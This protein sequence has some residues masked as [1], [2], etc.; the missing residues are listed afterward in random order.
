MA[1]SVSWPDELPL[2][3]ATPNMLMVTRISPLK[4]LGFGLNQIPNIRTESQRRALALYREAGFSNND[5]LS[6]LFYW[7]IL[8]VEGRSAARFVDYAIGKQRQQ[9]RIPSEYLQSL[10][11]GRRSHG[12][13]FLDDCRHAIAHI[14]RWKGRREIDFDDREV[15]VRF[16]YSVQVNQGGCAVLY[17]WLATSIC[18]SSDRGAVDSPCMLT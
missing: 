10:P 12:Q 4:A 3:K 7:Q 13:Y 18:I 9:L 6:F 17:S 5:Y 1:G 11:R 8:E 15:R 2:T 14:S 16:F